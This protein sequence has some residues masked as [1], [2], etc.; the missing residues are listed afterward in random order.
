MAARGARR[1]ESLMVELCTVVRP[2]PNVVDPATGV[3]SP[4]STQVYSGRCKVNTYEPY[5]E[6]RD[7]SGQT[8]VSQR[9]SV[10]VPLSAGP[11]AVGDVVAVGSRRF[12]VGGTHQKSFQTAQRL[13]CDELTGGVTD[14]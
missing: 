6:Q 14:G 8:V 12:R 4:S 3:V 9:Y 13:L 1:A 11:F 5:E 2:G 10:H 7:V